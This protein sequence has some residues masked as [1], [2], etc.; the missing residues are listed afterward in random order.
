MCEGI[1]YLSENII[2]FFQMFLFLPECNL[3]LVHILI[4]NSILDGWAIPVDSDCKIKFSN[5]F[6]TVGV[7]KLEN[8][9]NREH[10]AAMIHMKNACDPFLPKK[11]IL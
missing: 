3:N 10:L 7:H 9:T 6:D 8:L 11:L 4:V 1:L 2:Q 5:Y